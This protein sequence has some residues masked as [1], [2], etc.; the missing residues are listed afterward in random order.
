MFFVVAETMPQD[1]PKSLSPAEY[2]DIIS[3]VLSRNSMPAGEFELPSDMQKLKRIV[4]VEKPS[5]R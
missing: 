2:A 4:V 5:P 1:D 3:F